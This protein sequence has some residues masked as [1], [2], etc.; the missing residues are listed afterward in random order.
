M[1]RPPF[2]AR[3][4]G[5]AE[6]EESRRLKSQEVMENCRDRLGFSQFSVLDVVAAASGASWRASTNSKLWGSITEDRRLSCPS[7]SSSPSE[8]GRLGESRAFCLLP[9]SALSQE[10]MVTLSMLIGS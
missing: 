5:E 10:P 3:A 7:P 9:Q 1:V 4:A 2:V 6:E 8:G